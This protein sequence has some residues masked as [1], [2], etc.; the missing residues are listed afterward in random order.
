MATN[1]LLSLA[2]I[3]A[4]LPATLATA[5][6]RIEPGLVYWSL[7]A[8]ALAGPL[9]RAFTALTPAWN[10]GLSGALWLT[11]VA[12]FAL[13]ALIA[14]LS[15]DAWRLTPLLLSYLILVGIAAAIW[16]A[17]PERP[18][19]PAPGGW[20]A[21][22]VGISLATY[23]LLTIAAVAGFA[24]LVQ[25]RGL[26]RKQRGALNQMLPPIAAC[27]ALQARLLVATEIILGFGLATGMATEYFVAG[28][29][30]VLDHKT[31]FSL[32][33]FVL[34]GGLL[35][36]GARTGLGGRR[37]A[38]F[39]LLAYLLLTLAYPGVKFVTDVLLT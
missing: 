3:V 24:V 17:A 37:A 25:E 27:E 21:L 10:T 11:M 33:A 28:R 32:L 26:K 6:K 16:Q 36:V 22:H 38:R 29:P 19:L 2:A 7:L 30:L 14:A 18:L 20:L 35:L 8:V 34:I 13:F 4:L 12:S 39:V 9:L 15:R 23:G 31:L 5:V 1:L